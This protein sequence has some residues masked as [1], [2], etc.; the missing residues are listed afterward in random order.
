MSTATLRTVGGSVVMAIPKRLL[1][2]VDLQA[3]SQVDIDVQ[4]GRLIVVPQRKKRYK[5]AEL[6]AQ[7]DPNL[8]IL[9]EVQGRTTDFVV[10]AD[11]TVMHALALIYTVRDLPGVQQFKIVQHD[12]GRT[13]VL[14]VADDRFGEAERQRIIEIYQRY[15]RERLSP[16]VDGM[17]RAL[18]ADRRK[19][20]PVRALLGLPLRRIAA[21]WKPLPE[22]ELPVRSALLKLPALRARY[23]RF[24]QGLLLAALLGAIGLCWQAGPG[25]RGHRLL[26]AAVAL[27]AVTRSVVICSI[28]PFPVQRYLAEIFPAIL[29]L[30]GYAISRGIAL[31][32]ARLRSR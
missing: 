32:S 7:C 6:L 27:M 20:D 19:K 13:E 3:G 17:L 4:Q 16:E 8:P 5:L 23:A 1:E 24:E 12:I 18:A 15:N 28:H 22:Y 31:F 10:G 9:A 2:L 30:C 29:A 26:V 14:V 21:M 11:G 25:R